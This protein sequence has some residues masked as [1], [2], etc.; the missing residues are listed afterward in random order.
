MIKPEDIR[1]VAEATRAWT[2]EEWKRYAAIRNTQY[3]VMKMKMVMT[4]KDEDEVLHDVAAWQEWDTV[5][6]EP[7]QVRMS[8]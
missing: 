1:A 6:E 3:E 7:K 2:C 5:D 4:E 8:Y